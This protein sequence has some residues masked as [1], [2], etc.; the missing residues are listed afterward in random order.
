VLVP[1]PFSDLSSTKQRPV[2]V[3]AAP[4]A[5]GDF[6][7]VAVTS[8]TH[9][10]NAFAIDP[11]ELN[12]GALPTASWVRTDRVVTLNASLVRK[13]FGSASERLLE[14]VVR[15]VCERLGLSAVTEPEPASPKG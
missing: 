6:L 3:L 5:Y 14:Q 15:A 4:D 2:L 7:A 12:S 9:H 1:F 11:K 13:V 8:R 10:S